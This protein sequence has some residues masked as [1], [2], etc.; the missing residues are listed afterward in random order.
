MVAVYSV[1]P[2]RVLLVDDEPSDVRVL[3]EILREGYDIS[4]TR[5]GVRALEL[6][7][8]K[9]PAKRPDII[10]L[11]I[12]M[13]RP[14]GYEVLNQ[15]K[16]D[17]RTQDIPVVFVTSLDRVDDE[18]KGLELGAVEY[19]RKPFR[20]SIVRARVDNILTTR[21]YQEYAAWAGRLQGMGAEGEGAG[22]SRIL[23]VDDAPDE[24]RVL[25]EH[26]RE[27]YEVQVATSGRA[28]LEIIEADPPDCVLLDIL[29]PGLGGFA[30]LRR[31]K[32]QTATRHIPVI[33]VTALN[34]T[35]DEA[36][37]LKLG[38]VDYVTKP[39]KPALVKARVKNVVGLYRASR[40]A[41]R[42]AGA[43]DD[44][45][46]P[47]RR[48]FETYLAK[49]VQRLRTA[50]EPLGLAVIELP[51]LSAYEKAQGKGAADQVA[52]AAARA[53]LAQVEDD[54]LVASVD[55]GRFAAVL[56]SMEID[57]AES[58]ARVACRALA[59]AVEDVSL[60]PACGLRHDPLAA[61]PPHEMYERALALAHAAL[62]A[63]R[64]LL[65]DGE[66]PG[67]SHADRR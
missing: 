52:R 38:A 57:A 18:A 67:G 60:A 62:Q 65:T 20:P 26:L 28:A 33:V 13:P 66:T 30:L 34:Q 31:L 2:W 35:E 39:F 36:K 11:D 3:S 27:D 49:S 7:T 5:D 23:A 32:A 37:G 1:R 63:G 6:A 43:A 17:P 12:V 9:D 15:L 47:G 45:P 54:V 48:F 58:W 29:M 4:V 22:R 8:D 42:H 19:L 56:P 61:A 14:D 51:G 50:R 55:R 25:V 24:V 46:L 10:L 53:L 44:V 64:A 59:R 41:R 40:R 21:L 16:Q